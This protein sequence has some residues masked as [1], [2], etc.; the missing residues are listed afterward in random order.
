MHRPQLQVHLSWNRWQGILWWLATDSAWMISSPDGST[1]CP[2]LSGPFVFIMC[3]MAPFFLCSPLT[4]RFL[5]LL[6][7]NFRLAPLSPGNMD[8]WGDLKKDNTVFYSNRSLRRL[9][10]LV[11]LFSQEEGLP[12]GHVMQHLLGFIIT[13]D[14]V[15]KWNSQRQWWRIWTSSPLVRAFAPMGLC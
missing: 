13:L 6:C 7:W 11:L 10:I 5:F 4:R 12:I 14:K 9:V 15:G 3:S 8:I 1:T 2:F